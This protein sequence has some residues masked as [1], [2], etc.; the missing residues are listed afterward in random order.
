MRL[1]I[2]IFSCFILPWTVGIIFF[3]KDKKIFT[4]IAP[5]AAILAFILN[6]I[7]ID[8][9]LFYPLPVEYLK[10]NT[11]SIFADIGIL[12]VLSCMFIYL[13]AHT[14]IK[15][16]ILNIVIT[17]IATSI[18]WIFIATKFLE[19]DKGWNYL[20]SILMYF[21]SFGIIN[22]YYLWLKKLAIL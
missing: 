11:V 5:F 16:I 22:L 6:T 1:F 19:Y 13:V 10:A 2:I 17:V 8:L 4:T 7:G 3:F 20:F 14:K 12:S 18:D 9:G 21:I 15:P